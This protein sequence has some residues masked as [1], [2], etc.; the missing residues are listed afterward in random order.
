MKYLVHNYVEH[1]GWNFFLK[2]VLKIGVKIL[3]GKILWKERVKNVVEKCVVKVVAI[4]GFKV[5]CTNL[6]GKLCWKIVWSNRI[7]WKNLMD[8]LGDKLNVKFSWDKLGVKFVVINGITNL[9]GKWV[10][11]LV[12]KLSGIIGLRNWVGKGYIVQCTVK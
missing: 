1:F 11:S 10:H 4:L 12:T 5:K 6:V 3:G 7:A 2:I 8:N 9:V